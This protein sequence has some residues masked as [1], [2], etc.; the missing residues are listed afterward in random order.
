[1]SSSLPSR[2]YRIYGSKTGDRSEPA[3]IAWIAWIAWRMPVRHL[4]TWTNRPGPTDPTGTPGRHRDTGTTT[5]SYAVQCTGSRAGPAGQVQPICIPQTGMTDV[6][7]HYYRTVSHCRTVSHRVAPCRTVSGTGY[8]S[9]TGSPGRPGQIGGATD[10]HDVTLHGST[11]EYQHFR[12]LQDLKANPPRERDHLP[13]QGQ[14]QEHPATDHNTGYA[15]NLHTPLHQ[16]DSKN[17]GF[18]RI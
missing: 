15:A 8:L 18:F 7:P 1:M 11:G 4:D 3:C 10:R 5:S 9:P 6:T 13:A 17:K 2:I 12:T 14:D 16:L